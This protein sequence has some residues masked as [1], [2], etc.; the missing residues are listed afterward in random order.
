MNRWR[1]IR[2]RAREYRET[3]LSSKSG[4][5]SSL[6]FS[7]DLLS[8]ALELEDY[9]KYALP[10]NDPLLYGAISV[11]DRGA[12]SIW[13]SKDANPS[14]LPF[15]LAHELAHLHLRRHIT[16]CLPEFMPSLPH[17]KAASSVWSERLGYSLK[18]RREMEASVFA[19][20]FLL[21]IP[22]ARDLF[23]NGMDAKEISEH[24]GIAP[25][26][27]HTQLIEALL[28][29]I[30]METPVLKRKGQADISQ[31]RAIACED[32]ATLVLAGPG[33][34][35]TTSLISHAEYLLSNGVHPENILILTFSNNATEELYHRVEESYP[36]AAERIW[37]GTFHS[38]GLELIRRF[39][40][41]IN[42]S[43]NAT[44]IDEVDAIPLMER[45]LER[46]DLS[47]Y[48]ACSLKDP[49]RY[50]R[51]IYYT[52]SRCK[53]ELLYPDNLPDYSSEIK[54]EI[55]E[56]E[57]RDRVLKFSQVYEEWDRILREEGRMDF[58]DL[59]AQPVRILQSFPEALLQI[60]TEFPHI[61]VDEYQDINRAT[62]VLIE[63]LSGDGRGLWAVGDNRQAIYGFRGAYGEN[64]REFSNRYHDA[65]VMNLR[66]NYRSQPVIVDMLNQIATHENNGVKRE[67][68]L[69]HRKNEQATI[70]NIAA[71]DKNDQL[72]AM[73]QIINE[74][75]SQGVPYSSQ[76]I[77]CRTYDQAET[78]SGYMESNRVP[79]LFLGSLTDRN[80]VKDMLAILSYCRNGDAVSKD[81]ILQFAE[82]RGKG[83]QSESSNDETDTSLFES[84]MDTLCRIEN[85]FKLLTHYLYTL[86]GYLRR[87]LL[88]NS[89]EA[90]QERIVLN[91][92]LFLLHSHANRHID[93]DSPGIGEFLDWVALVENLDMGGKINASEHMDYVN[94]VRVMTLHKSKGLEFPSV[95]IP[96]L[97]EMK[98]RRRGTLQSLLPFYNPDSDKEEMRLYFVGVSR[99]MDRLTLLHTDLN[100]SANDFIDLINNVIPPSVYYKEPN[101]DVNPLIDKDSLI[102]AGTLQDHKPDVTWQGLQQF[103][104]CP[105]RYHYLTQFGFPTIFNRR[106]YGWFQHLVMSRIR[107]MRDRSINGA[108]ISREE[109]IFKYEEEWN[110]PGVPDNQYSIRLKNYGR[111]LLENYRELTLREKPIPPTN[112]VLSLD[113]GTIRIPTDYISE[114]ERN[115]WIIYIFLL[116]PIRRE[117]KNLPEIALLRKA[118][119]ESLPEIEF[120]ITLYSLY[121]NETMK[122]DMDTPRELRRIEKYRGIIKSLGE[123]CSSTNPGY[124][125]RI[126]AFRLICSR[127]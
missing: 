99:A 124:E 63:L 65:K 51:N 115:H 121:D 52:I 103:E 56:S 30:P 90:L 87:L 59:I 95:I 113:Y 7:D 125:C 54:G 55:N 94:A 77:L 23:M 83:G 40:N 34:G 96:F 78:V 102:S 72:S 107:D 36:D 22:V 53:D 104:K 117:D 37:I 12:Q 61:L 116:D 4:L 42:F 24:V 123:G 64:F 68:W 109:D 15:Y 89:V 46:L 10:P 127:T 18:E 3:V 118:V 1:L 39:G 84:H 27:I 26:L 82:Y 6:P 47:P 112:I 88:E 28:P 29:D 98:T 44:L 20:E 73:V 14:M 62:T 81:R 13:Y 80:S 76:V 66:R 100:K 85:P 9:S 32:G 92:F 67:R 122:V 108:V 119:M 11:L 35:K 105:R 126:C 79:T 16:V 69:P 110:A 70:R 31:R 91:Q 75:K 38:F 101:L 50:F 86:S 33:T 45:Y 93:G 43:Q 106:H 111:R 49:I 74:D 19:V 41:L 114:C 25:E 57:K 17:P 120:E 5:S 71:N 60:R 2:Q 97:E 8:V 58:G 48:V 21:P